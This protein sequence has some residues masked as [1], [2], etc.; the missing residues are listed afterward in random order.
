MAWTYRQSTGEMIDPSGKV[1]GIGYSGKGAAKNDPGKERVKGEGPIPKGRW[2]I[3]ALRETTMNH[4]P[5][6]LV[7]APGPKT[8]TYGRSGFLCHGDNKDGTASLG[9]II[10]RRS[11]RETIWTSGDRDLEVIA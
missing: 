1:I 7:L 11:V 4:G 6:V 8:R 9:C 10:Q 5:Y 3:T 2:K